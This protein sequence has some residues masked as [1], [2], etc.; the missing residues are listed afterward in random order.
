MHFFDEVIGSDVNC[1]ERG[2]A[3]VVDVSIMWLAQLNAW[4]AT[5]VD[6]ITKRVSRGSHSQKLYSDINGKY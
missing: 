4:I 2:R 5:V 6:C 3:E 1:K